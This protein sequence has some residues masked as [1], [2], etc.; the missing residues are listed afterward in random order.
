MIFAAYRPHSAIV[1]WATGCVLL[2]TPLIGYAIISIHT[3]RRAIIAAWSYTLVAVTVVSLICCRD[4]GV[5]RMLAICS[6][7]LYAM[8]A[9]VAASS[10]AGDGLRL[11]FFRWIAFA[12]F[13]PGMQ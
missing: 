2:L 6:T 1:F 11:P 5:F 8:K 7:L 3:P 12:Y 4:T 13:W 10:Q 9:V